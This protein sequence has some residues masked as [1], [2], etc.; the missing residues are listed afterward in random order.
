MQ[1]HST[2]LRMTFSPAVDFL[3]QDHGYKLVA[4]KIPHDS[5]LAPIHPGAVILSLHHGGG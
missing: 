3:D 5:E 4:I 1:V 2:S